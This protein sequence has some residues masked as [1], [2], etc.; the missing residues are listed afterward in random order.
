MLG[1]YMTCMEMYGSGVG[2]GMEIIQPK[3][4]RILWARPW[5]LTALIAVEAGTFRLSL[6][7][8]R[9]VASMLRRLGPPLLASALSA[10]SFR[11]EPGI[12]RL[13]QVRSPFR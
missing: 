11:A 3:R 12:E 5:G 7:A 8:L 6:F 9:T 2:I 13:K 10:L 4:R 1:V